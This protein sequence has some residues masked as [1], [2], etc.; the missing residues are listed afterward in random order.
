VANESF[1]SASAL[2]NQQFAC[3]GDHGTHVASLAAGLSFGLAK[4]ATIVPV[5]VYPGCDKQGKVSD[6]AIGLSWILDDVAD[7]RLKWSNDEHK[8]PIIVTISLQL[9]LANPSSLIIEVMVAQLL[10]E[11]IIVVAAAGNNSGDSCDFSPGGLDDVITV[12]ALDGYRSW[13]GSNYGTC[14]DVWAPG[15]DVVGAS[16]DCYRCSAAYTG[17][18]QATPIVAGLVATYLE[19]RPEATVSDVREWLLSHAQTLD[20]IPER[21]ALQ[22]AKY[23]S[24]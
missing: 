2:A 6:L 12:G 20:D 15:T 3:S 24:V 7:Q 23:A 17:T 1:V 16:P 9:P 19:T 5:V 22:A 21:V 8:Q 18:S 11:G 14:V 13:T 4:N 10:A